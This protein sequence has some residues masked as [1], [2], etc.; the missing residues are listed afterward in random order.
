MSYQFGIFLYDTVRTKISQD[1]KLCLARA[2]GRTVGQVDDVTL[3]WPV[4]CTV[5][6]IDEIGHAFG[7][8]MVARS[9]AFVAIHALLRHGPLAF[10]SDK[11]SMEVQIETVLDGRAV[12]LGHQADCPCQCLPVKADALANLGFEAFDANACHVRRKH[13][14]QVRLTGARDLV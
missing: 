11:E 2:V 1:I 5:R 3:G 10:I 12:Y 7:M 9:L 13:G 14:C 8:P 4:N 6:R